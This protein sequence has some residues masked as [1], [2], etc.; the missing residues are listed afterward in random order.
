MGLLQCGF[1]SPRSRCP[2]MGITALGLLCLQW[3]LLLEMRMGLQLCQPQTTKKLGGKNP[4]Y[5]IALGLKADLLCSA[6]STASFGDCCLSGKSPWLPTGTKVL[7]KGNTSSLSPH[8]LDTSTKLTA[9]GCAASFM[10]GLVLR[11]ESLLSLGRNV[12]AAGK[13]WAGL[14]SSHLVRLKPSGSGALGAVWMSWA[15][16]LRADPTSVPH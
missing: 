2:R 11:L 10:L 16:V 7:G 12:F 14:I 5:F 6:S 4:V 13:A 8:S 1:A 9:A 3:V 15:A